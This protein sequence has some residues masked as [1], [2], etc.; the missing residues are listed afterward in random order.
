MLTP[1]TAADA[2]LPVYIACAKCHAPSRPL[3]IAALL[4]AG[5]GE[6][7]IES[8]AKRGAFRCTSCGSRKAVVMPIMADLV[9]KQCRLHRRCIDC[10]K[11]AQLTAVDAVQ[12]F[13]FATPLDEVRRREQG[14][15]RAAVCHLSISFVSTAAALRKQQ[16]GL[17]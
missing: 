14:R 12:R 3:D 8:S 17:S 2:G 11:D 13:G 4:A 1:R 10:G 9:R 5:R 7:D 15:C 6:L 16:F